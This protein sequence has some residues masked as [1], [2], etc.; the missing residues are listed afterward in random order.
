MIKVALY[1][2]LAHAEEM[3]VGRLGVVEYP[4]PLSHTFAPVV[5]EG[6][7]HAVA[8]QIVLLAVSGGDCLRGNGGCDLAHCV[9]VGLI[10]QVRVQF[11][12]FLAQ[13]ACQHHFAIGC[14]A[15]Q[16]VGSEVLVVVGVDRLPA[17]LLLQVVGCGLLDQGVFGVGVWV[18]SCAPS[19]SASSAL[20][21]SVI[22]Y[23]C[24][25]L[26]GLSGMVISIQPDL[27]RGFR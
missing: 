8:D 10:W 11:D 21:F 4:H 5:A 12:E 6:D 19:T 13:G 20:P 15:K 2:Q 3:V 1:P 25:L 27:R 23:F 18:H 14:T 9:V 24:L 7:L 16:A 17:E 26:V 22:R